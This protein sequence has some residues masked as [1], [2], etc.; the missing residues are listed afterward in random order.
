MVRAG[1]PRGQG[2]GLRASPTL[3]QAARGFLSRRFLT[4]RVACL[5]IIG[6][7]IK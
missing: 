5:S 7:S 3:C 4:L 2:L 6:H 1:R